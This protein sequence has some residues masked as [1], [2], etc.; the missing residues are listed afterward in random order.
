MCGR[1][2]CRLSGPSFADSMPPMKP[3]SPLGFLYAVL[4]FVSWGLF[5][6]YWKPFAGVSP[7]EILSHR[8]IWSLVVLAGAVVVLGQ[9][10]EALAVVRT[11]RRA[12]VLLLTA[13]LLSGNW[14]LFIYGVI[15]GQVVQ[16]SLGYFLN[17]LLSILLGFV[18]LKERLTKPQ[19]VAVLLAVCGVVHFGWLLGRFPWIAVGLAV[20][21]GF[22][23]MLRKIVAVTPLVGLLV[24]TAWMAPAALLFLG[25]Q[26]QSSVPAFGASASLTMLFL[27]AG[28]ITALPLFWF[29]SAA[30]LLPL[31]TM[32]FLQFLAPTLQL[33]VGVLI[34][35]E[36]FSQREMVSFALIWVAVGIYLATL[37]KGRPPEVVANPD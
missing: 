27:G 29:N 21:F 9:A 16:T 10:R 15:S 36:P 12:S 34:F 1:N 11:P 3:L 8:V 14:A 37:W 22:Y 4:A 2:F 7:W 24:E 26:A 28:V 31:S 35:R 6:L 23:G 32:G 33:A 18:F 13:M 17:P 5:P 30:K 20:S 25:W 19:T